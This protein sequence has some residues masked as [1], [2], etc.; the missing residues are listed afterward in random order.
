MTTFG[1]LVLFLINVTIL[2]I[3]VYGETTEHW[4]VFVCN[5]YN[6]QSLA[7]ANLGSWQLLVYLHS[8]Q[9][10]QCSSYHWPV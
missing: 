9:Y 6:T 1:L 4:A 5:S 8:F 3:A 2:K 7:S 10:R